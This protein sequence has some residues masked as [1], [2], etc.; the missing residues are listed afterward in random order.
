[1]REIVDWKVVHRGTA[2]DLIH[3]PRRVDVWDAYRCADCGSNVGVA[4]V[5]ADGHEF[6]LCLNC[7]LCTEIEPVWGDDESRV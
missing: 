5:D 2:D 7:H 3:N 4:V 6:D 1:M